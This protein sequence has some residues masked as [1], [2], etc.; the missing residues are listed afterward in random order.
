MGKKSG[1]IENSKKGAKFFTATGKYC[2]VPP[3]HY[4]SPIVNTDEIMQRESNIWS[5]KK[6]ISGID[7]NIEEQKKLLND[8][9]KYYDEM[10]FEAEKKEG[11]R[12]YF[13][14]S[15]YSYTDG[16]MLH[17]MMRHFKPKHIIEVGSGFSSAVMLD[18]RDYFKMDTKMSFIEPYPDRLYSLMSEKDKADNEVLVKDIQEVP[19]SFFEK[20]SENDM[21]FIDSTHVSKTGSDVNYLFFEILPLLKKGVLVHIHDVF[22]SFEYPKSWVYEGRSWNEDYLLRAFLMYNDSF[23]IRLFSN[24]IH[25]HYKDYFTDLPLTYNNTGGNIWIQRK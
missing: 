21:L 12:Y 1:F 9:K 24:Y 14:N 6:E 11:L 2:Y 15:F 4:Y 5:G 22:A 23:K 19:L 13:E 18:T 17:C 25:T 20:L 8:F 7:L 10:P 3:G 16:L